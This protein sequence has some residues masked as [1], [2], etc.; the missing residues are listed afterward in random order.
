MSGPNIK[1]IPRKGELWLVGI[2]FGGPC[3]LLIAI[4]AWTIWGNSA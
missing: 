2:A 3:L 1:G 4:L